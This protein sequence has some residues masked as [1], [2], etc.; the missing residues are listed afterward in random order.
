MY[1]FSV[2]LACVTHSLYISKNRYT[3]LRGSWEDKNEAPTIRVSSLDRS[4]AKNKSG[5]EPFREQITK[6][7]KR[8][9]RRAGHAHTTLLLLLPISNEEKLR[10]VM[11]EN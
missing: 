11:G 5:N 4:A 3:F 8:V 7:Y 1:S 9:F 10:Y 2:I 6:L